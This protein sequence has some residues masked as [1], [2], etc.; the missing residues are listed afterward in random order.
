MPPHVTL[1]AD[2][3]STLKLPC[4]PVV[5]TPAPQPDMPP[6]IWAVTNLTTA[7]P[8]HTHPHHSEGLSKPTTSTTVRAIIN[9]H[10]HP[11]AS[12]HMWTSS[13]PY[14]AIRVALLTRF[15]QL[16]CSA[17]AH[18]MGLPYQCSGPLPAAGGACPLCGAPLCNPGH[19]MGACTHPSLKRLYINRHNKA[20]MLL[21]AAVSA[22]SKSGMLCIMMDAGRACTL[23]VGILGTRLPKW[24]IPDRHLPTI[25]TDTNRPLCHTAVRRK[26]RPDILYIA[27][28]S[29]TLTRAGA[30]IPGRE[31]KLATIHIIEV[32]Y[33]SESSD[34]Y[35]DRIRQKREQHASLCT[36]L[37]SAGWRIHNAQPTVLMLG[38][39]GTVFS[40][41]PAALK[42]L[43]IARNPSCAFFICLRF[44]MHSPSI[45]NA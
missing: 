35:L 28:L 36:A 8:K 45:H 13:L 32:G 25:L 31:K 10:A 18:R 30:S 11:D 44:A 5:L 2:N 24:L 4:W 9:R 19:I 42:T 41:W 17:R 34:A 37:T 29:P 38:Q 15:N 21:Q 14:G 40:E 16:H 27:N 23:P 43:H 1:D 39:A 22:G 20:V 26:L 12:N 7:L 3:E 33:V 6:R